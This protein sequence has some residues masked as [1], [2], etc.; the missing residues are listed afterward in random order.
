MRVYCAL[1]DN[2][3]HN[4]YAPP[5]REESVSIVKETAQKYSQ[6]FFPVGVVM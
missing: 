1:T 3:F 2:F 5:A 4:L 6:P